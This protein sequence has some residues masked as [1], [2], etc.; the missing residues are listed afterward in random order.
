MADDVRKFVERFGK[1]PNDIKKNMRPGLREAGKV[2]ALDAKGRAEWSTRIPRAISVRT[3]FSGKRAGVTVRVARSKAP[4][5]RAYEHGGEPGTFRHPV[6]PS[7][8]DRR[9]WNW[10]AQAARPFLAPALQAKGNEAA[11][12]IADVVNRQIREACR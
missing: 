9:K 2:V 3:S 6:F 10:T 5:A 4:H 7:G 8:A 12:K 11:G 1:V